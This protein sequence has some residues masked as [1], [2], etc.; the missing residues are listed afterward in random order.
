MNKFSDTSFFTPSPI[1]PI[2]E[3]WRVAAARKHILIGG[4]HLASTFGSQI[5][6]E[7]LRHLAN[8]APCYYGIGLPNNFQSAVDAYLAPI[9]P[10]P[11]KAARRALVKSLIETPIPY[12]GDSSINPLK[13][14]CALGKIFQ[15]IQ[16]VGEGCSL[17]LPDASCPPHSRT[18]HTPAASASARTASP[19]TRFSD[20]VA[21]AF[22]RM[23]TADVR[24]NLGENCRG[25]WIC[26]IEH[27]CEIRGLP[28]HFSTDEQVRVY[29]SP[30]KPELPKSPLPPNVAPPD[31]V[32]LDKE[33]AR[34]T[35]S[36]LRRGIWQPENS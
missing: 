11:E 27:F 23:L 29:I 21:P 2:E 28:A 4:T 18:S 3:A 26:S 14:A 33:N 5:V 7:G 10:L 6:G 13:Q 17:V 32:I 35:A 8:E 36:G 30:E 31:I 12:G 19:F 9:S 16:T 24:E 15:H 34:V 1:I 20:S 25:I 22:N